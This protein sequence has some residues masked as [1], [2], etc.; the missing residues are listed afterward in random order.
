MIVVAAVISA[1]LLVA[2]LYPAIKEHA[3]KSGFMLCSLL[4]GIQFLFAF[5]LKEF[6]FSE[7]Y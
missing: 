5:V 1:G 6:F 2:N 3:P 4:F 7:M